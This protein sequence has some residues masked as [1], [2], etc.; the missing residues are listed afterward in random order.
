M[1]SA[2]IIQ[3]DPSLKQKRRLAESMVSDSKQYRPIQH[4]L[5]GAAQLAQAASGKYQLNKIDQEQEDKHQK[6]A[7]VISGYDGT[8]PEIFDG[9]PEIQSNIKFSE[10]DRKRNLNDRKELMDY[11]SNLNKP[12]QQSPNLPQGYMWNEN[13]NKAERIPGLPVQQ[14]QRSTVK[15]AEGYLRYLDGDRERVFPDVVK[16]VEPEDTQQLFNNSDK[17]RDEFVSQSKDFVKVRDSFGRIKQSAT[18]PSP[19]G[20]LSMIF[21]YM[22]MLDPA[23]VVRE[24]EFA[25]AANAAPLLQRMGIS[26]DKVASVWDGKKLTDDQRTDFLNRARALYGQQLESQN[27]LSNTYTGLANRFELDPQN[28][29]IDYDNGL[30]NPDTSSH[31]EYIDANSYASELVNEYGLDLPIEQPVQNT[32]PQQHAERRRQQRGWRN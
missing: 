18:N 9:Y 13:L 30:S 31:H 16:P 32:R 29:V 24:S 15:D 1:N 12:K 6:L 3:E 10:I 21:N 26:F 8:N 27:A 17:L 22:K 19:A 14:Q 25:L 28:V 2:M 7:R 4:W 11:Q 5:Q 20:D 23:S